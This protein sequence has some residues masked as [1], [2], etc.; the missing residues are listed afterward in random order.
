MLWLVLPLLV[1][2]VTSAAVE[3]K[4]LKTQEESDREGKC[5]FATHSSHLSAFNTCI[6]SVFSIFQIVKFNNDACSAIDGTTGTC[7]TASECTA[8][9]GQDKGPCASGF[10]VCCVGKNYA[11]H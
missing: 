1:S 11:P 3:E 4:A 10:G 9:G 6:I 2:T 5:K 7:Y 8:N